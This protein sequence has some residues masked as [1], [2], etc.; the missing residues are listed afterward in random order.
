[1]DSLLAAGIE[2]FVTLYHWDLPQELED[3]GGW[4]ARDTTEAFAEFVEVV[5]GRL[6]DRVH[7]W[8]TICEPWVVSW[9]GYGTGEHA[10]GHR[11]DVEALAAVHHVLLA[12]AR[13]LE[14][15]RRDANAQVGITIDLLRVEP[16]SR[17]PADLAAARHLDGSRNRWILDPVLRGAYPD[18]LV[19]HFGAKLPPIEDGD[20]AAIA[21]PLD[22]L[23]VNY[24]TRNVVAAGA[25]AKWQVVETDRPRTAMGWEVYPEGLSQLLV[26]LRDEYEIPPLFV[27]E[28]G[29]AYDDRVVRGVV[30]DP[31]RIAYLAAHVDALGR[32]I[33][34]G[35]PVRGY[36]LW[37]L[38]DNFE[39]AWGYSRRF[40]I[41]HVDFDTLERTPKASFRWYQQ[42]IA[43]H[44]ALQ[45]AAR[46]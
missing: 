6:G 41:V 27:T 16:A 37:S 32:A 7:W 31:E 34:A 21:A 13:A 9:L 24:Y 4:P 45:Y 22:F 14:V 38:L 42:L 23:G 15:L 35:V 8:F 39:W 17:A 28:N 18:D 3:R 2:P 29:A 25:G 33:E 5:N 30:D 1:V 10:P 46:P 12:H 40:G 19:T 20:L 36:F 44:A 43:R 26:R 11:S